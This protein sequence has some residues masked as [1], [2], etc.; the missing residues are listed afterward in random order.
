[1]AEAIIKP[2]L[3]RY[4]TEALEEFGRL[5][6]YLQETEEM[7]RAKQQLEAIVT[8]ER[9]PAGI[10]EK[11]GDDLYV[12]QKNGDE[13]F[14]GT[15]K[16]VD[17]FAEQL[18]KSIDDNPYKN[19]DELI[20]ATKMKIADKMWKEYKY[21]NFLDKP[22][23]KPCFLAGTLIHTK[24]GLVPIEKI[25]IGMEVLCYDE[26]KQ[27]TTSQKVSET[28]TNKAEKYIIIHT[29]SGDKI[30]ATGQ[31]LFYQ[32]LS[33]TWV[34][35]H[36]LTK[37]MF[38][39]NAINNSLDAIVK[40]EIIEKNAPT[41][42]FE[43]PIH[44]NYLVGNAGLLTHNAS[45][46][47]TVDDL[48]TR[49]YQFYQLYEEVNL[50]KNLFSKNTHYIGKTTRESLFL[51]AEEHIYAAIKKG[52]KSKHYWK[53]QIKFTIANLNDGARAFVEMTEI[54]SAVWEK[55]FLEK[56]R[57]ETGSSLKNIQNPI[58][59]SRFNA[60]KASGKHKNVCIFFI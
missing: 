45:K 59:E 29:Q 14:R 2:A 49:K 6:R 42:N 34:K 38:L 54:Q 28:F 35:A 17:E 24:T 32:K 55:Y 22:P 40:L 44:H 39:Y 60:L 50:G 13:V 41:Y 9:Y 56:Y 3:K 33:K 25:E 8:P 53:F 52:P 7:A 15:K 27:T 26:I 20:Y 10:P 18:K 36:A 21:L 16:E 51:R 57:F 30:S 19:V 31:H 1:M 12:L 11:I 58:S 37:G 43:V 23:K 48:T 5:N 47:K 4:A 46:F